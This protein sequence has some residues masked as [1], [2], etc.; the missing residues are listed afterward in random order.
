MKDMLPL[1]PEGQA[2]VEENMPL[3]KK[4]MFRYGL[5]AEHYGRLAVQFT[6]IAENVVFLSQ[7][8]SQ[9]I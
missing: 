2:F 5:G 1:T 7:L 4:F 6:Q 8:P 9:N 3:L